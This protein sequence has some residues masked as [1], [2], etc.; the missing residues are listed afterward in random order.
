MPEGNIEQPETVGPQQLGGHDEMT[1]DLN[2]RV[3][4]EEEI[5]AR[6]FREENWGDDKARDETMAYAEDPYR[7]EA[8]N[9]RTAANLLEQYPLKLEEVDMRLKETGDKPTPRL[10]PR[11]ADKQAGR[12]YDE[13]RQAIINEGIE[14]SKKTEAALEK[15]GYE[16]QA[17]HSFIKNA[18]NARHS[19]FADVLRE[20][21]TNM[22]R[23][24]K[25]SDEIAAAMGELAGIAHSVSETYKEAHPGYDFSPEGIM[26]LKDH[27]R[28]KQ[29]EIRQAELYADKFVEG[30]A[31][32]GL[33]VL[34]QVL[35]LEL[36]G[37]TNEHIWKLRQLSDEQQADYIDELE[38]DAEL[39]RL[40][41]DTEHT[42]LQDIRH[43]MQ[44]AAKEEVEQLQVEIDEMQEVLEDLYGDKA[45][46][47]NYKKAEPHTAEIKE[48]T[49]ATPSKDKSPEEWER[50]QAQAW[51]N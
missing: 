34:P 16:G 12:E 4:T 40:L 31:A 27:V 37:L 33:L 49:V 17:A 41:S 20:R 51:S 10:W 6:K 1:E 30:G 46:D 50:E 2:K 36:G 35:E 38:L 11:A 29:A 32:F 7:T 43:Y 23:A 22:R 8:A 14:H 13:K 48:E 9:N 39:V 28:A 25:R 3:P 47:P 21:T 42:T 24:A 45:S 19:G 15:I 26:L 5:E 44:Q 18:G